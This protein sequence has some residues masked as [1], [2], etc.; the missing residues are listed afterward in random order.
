MR[1]CARRE[2]PPPP[3]AQAGGHGPNQL[4]FTVEE[5]TAARAVYAPPVCVKSTI[6]LG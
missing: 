3:L 4:P 1:A 6:A 2:F 5:S